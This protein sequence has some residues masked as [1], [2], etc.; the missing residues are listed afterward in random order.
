MSIS[1]Q[2]LFWIA[3]LAAMLVFLLVFSPILLPFVGGMAL[4]YLLDPVADSFE[5]SGFSRLAATLTIM[6]LSLIV[7]VIVMFLILPVLVNQLVLLIDNVPSYLER[8]D[9][10]IESVLKSRWAESSVTLKP[11]DRIGSSATT[12]MQMVGWLTNRTTTG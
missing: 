10:L 2:I 8:L 9:L 3:S 5:R 4:A 1:R 11:P 12:S 7:F 6:V